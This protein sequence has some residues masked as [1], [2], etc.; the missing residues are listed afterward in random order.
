[1]KGRS[2]FSKSKVNQVADRLG[3]RGIVYREPQGRTCRV[4]PGEMVRAARRLGLN[5]YTRAVG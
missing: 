3:D 2:D 4:Y 1:M 5:P